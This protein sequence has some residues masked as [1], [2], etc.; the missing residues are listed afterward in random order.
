[1]KRTLCILAALLIL[2]SLSLRAAAVDTSRTGSVTFT[3]VWEE[4]PIDTGALTLY[5]VGV[6]EVVDGTYAY[7]PVETLSDAVTF[8]ELS[9]PAL[10]QF[11]AELVEERN[12]TGTMAPIRHGEAAFMDL[13][14]G[15]YLVVQKAE[16]AS[17]GFAPI[18]PFLITVPQYEDG[19]Y[20]YD[21]TAQPKVPLYTEPTET[22]E[23]PTTDPTNPTDPPDLPQ[24][25]QLY[26]PV[27]V[28][29]VSG[30]AVF[31]LGLAMRT[32]K[33]EDYEA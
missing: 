25:G 30:I 26:W 32:R 21:I 13:T 4:E 18:S 6:V 12:V 10:A 3:L 9:S 14:L 2:G 7:V 27:P 1:M 17:D 29:A 19:A 31:M 5:Q 33:R 20:T 11:L 23:P 22:T 24:T 15:V 16:D 8:E 28:L